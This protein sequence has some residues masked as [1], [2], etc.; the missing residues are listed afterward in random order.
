MRL[1]AKVIRT[2]CLFLLNFIADLRLYKIFK[3][4]WMSFLDTL[5][6][7]LFSMFVLCAW[8]SD[9]CIQLR[10]MGWGIVKGIPSPQEWSLGVVMPTLQKYFPIWNGA[11]ALVHLGSILSGLACRMSRRWHY[12]RSPCGHADTKMSK[13]IA[14]CCHDCCQCH[15]WTARSLAR[16]AGYVTYTF[17]SA[18]ITPLLK[19]PDLDSAD[20]TSYRPISH[21]SVLSKLLER[22]VA[23]QLLDYLN[24]HQIANQ[25]IGHTT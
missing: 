22:L 25:R 19:K 16:R 6:Y 7:G 4:T 17:K 8:R 11:C 10:T 23:R 13:P 3:I 12:I 20:V 14:G 21:L 9:G 1:I 5:Y 24:A 18:F 2:K 15:D